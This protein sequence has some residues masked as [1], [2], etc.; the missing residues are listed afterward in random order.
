M[1]FKCS[2]ERMSHASL[3]LNLEVI[4]FSEEGMSKGKIGQK[5]VFLCPQISQVVN[6]K[7]KFL[8]EMKSAIPMFTH[9]W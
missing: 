5:L 2:S 7:E 4:K 6:V 8:K 1:A 9:K 3:T